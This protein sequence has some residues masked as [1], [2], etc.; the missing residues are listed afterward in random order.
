MATVLVVDD[1]PIVREVV[2][3]YLARDGH[4]TMEARDG[5]AARPA[6]RGADPT[7]SFST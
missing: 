4:D 7:S 3:R 1:E 6:H 5:N 2:V